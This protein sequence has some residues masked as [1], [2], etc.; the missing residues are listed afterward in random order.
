MLARVGYPT[1]GGAMARPGSERSGEQGDPGHPR[2]VTALVLIGTLVAFLAIFSIWVNR[3]ALNT[4]NWVDT[5]DGLLQNEEVR[6]QPSNYLA[7]QLI[8]NVDVQG[9]L[10]SR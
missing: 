7:D 5:S 10:E 8:A 1:R 4:E 6:A 3:Q 9:E 2:A